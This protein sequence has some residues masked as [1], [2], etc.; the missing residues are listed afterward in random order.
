LLRTHETSAGA[1]KI[2]RADCIEA[3]Y[4]DFMSTKQRLAEAI[5]ALPDSLTIEE[6]VERLYQAF[7][8]KQALEQGRGVARAPVIL[9]T[10]GGRGPRPGVDLDNS[11]A[12][13]EVMEQGDGPP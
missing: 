12:L 6:A 1:V 10:V 3:Q 5:A 4:R 2:L 8:R 13:R 9:P 11:A 7:K